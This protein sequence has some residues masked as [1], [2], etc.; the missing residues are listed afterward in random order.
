MKKFLVSCAYIYPLCPLNINHAKMFVVADIIARN[1][2]RKGKNVFFPVASH[3]SGNSAQD[4]SK[5][6][7]KIFSKDNTIE[8]DEEKRLFNLYNDI[9]N[10]PLPIL[11]TF[12]Y[13]LNILGFYNQEILQ[14]LKSLG[15]SCDYE[16]FYT[17]G[18]KDF[19]TFVNTI[20][21]IY[22]EN[23]LL[24]NN[25]KGN[26]ALDYNNGE[27][28]EKAL[29]L[30]NRTEFLQSFHKNNVVSA[31]KDVRNDWSLLRKNGFGVSYKKWIIDPMFDSEIFTIFDLYIKLKDEYKK[32]INV[33]KFFRN[34][35]KTL[36]N[37]QKSEDI[38]INKIIEFLPCDVLIC[39]EH[40]K[41]W[42]VKKIY[43]ES[44]LLY[45]KYQ[46]KKYFILG[47]GFLDGKQMSAS[48]GHAI[49]A[50][51]LIDRY[52]PIKARLIILLGGGHP[53]KMYD[54]DKT[55]PIQAD[56]L[57][58]NFIS[59]YTQLLSFVDREIKNKFRE[60]EL[61]TESICNN[62]E[63]NIEKGYYRQAIIELLSILPKKYYKS[64]TINTALIL[65]SVYDKYINVLLPGL[66]NNFVCY[67]KIHSKNNKI[68]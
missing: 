15:V 60:E 3:Y 35:F 13:P 29:D 55:L 61:I 54:Y 33:E 47:M 44:L 8:N 25:K 21:S 68:L 7:T 23:N 32:P 30:I 26:L 52:G 49:L 11:K 28:K 18:H 2:R 67:E 20:I 48:K 19:S 24:V 22:K 34:L 43:A 63:D 38:L 65:I 56:K 53:S 12:V 16:H 66:L 58:N 9:Y 57:L 50:K 17:T 1:E 40:L 5:I 31:I 51:D 4:I 36:K 14:E 45:D 46:T 37:K 6:F 64:P 42:V 59:H 10:T 41:N 39:E 62:I 27:W